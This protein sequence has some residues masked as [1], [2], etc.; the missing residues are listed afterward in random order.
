MVFKIHLASVVIFF[1]TVLTVNGQEINEIK[2]PQIA[3]TISGPDKICLGT[4]YTYTL[5]ENEAGFIYVW[6]VN[7]GQVV[8]N[9]TG[10]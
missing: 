10:Q 9:N 2:K 5:S 6:S 7:N 4:P 1:L 8:G 3:G